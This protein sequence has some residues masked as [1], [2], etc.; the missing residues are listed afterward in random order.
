[1]SEW[2]DEGIKALEEAIRAGEVF[3]DR[4]GDGEESPKGLPGSAETG[5][6]DWE[7]AQLVPA[8]MK[9]GG[10][11]VPE[12][13]L[14]Q[15]RRLAKVHGERLTQAVYHSETKVSRREI[16]VWFGNFSNFRVELGLRANPAMPESG[17]T[18]EEMLAAFEEL[19]GREGEA[20]TARM[21][22][23]E[24]GW[25]NGLV[26]RRFGSFRALRE[27]FG[28]GRRAPIGKM[29]EDA[30]L[31]ADALR[32]WRL[33]AG[34]W[35]G[36]PPRRFLTTTEYETHGRFSVPTLYGRF[37]RWR[38]VEEAVRAASAGQ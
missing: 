1:M 12:E 35:V 16:R 27:R 36:E 6:R 22:Y 21:F 30:E 11:I 2:T 23:R 38:G 33:V 8:G 18:E 37:G 3:A 13:M 29:I 24:T 7:F 10:R 20:V 31:V 14:A 5:M 15:G 9:L 4:V 25:N 26:Q 19:A 28:L 32:V 17:P 34:E